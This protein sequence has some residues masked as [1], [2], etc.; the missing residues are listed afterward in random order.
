[1]INPGV[2]Y[3][4]ALKGKLSKEEEAQRTCMVIVTLFPPVV[5]ADSMF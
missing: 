2:G 1:M 3:M 4:F 5:A